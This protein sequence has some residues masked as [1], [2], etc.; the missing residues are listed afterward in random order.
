MT[1]QQVYDAIHDNVSKLPPG[2]WGA[3]YTTGTPDIRWTDADWAKFPRAVR[4]CQDSGSDDTADVL[5]IENG[6]ATDEDAAAWYPRARDAFLA[7][8][9]PGQRHPALY[10]SA[11]FVTGLVNTL[12]AHGIT[13]GPSLFPANW[14]EADAAVRAEIAKAG[15]PFPVIGV[16]NHNFNSDDESLIAESWLTA[17][18]SRPFFT[19]TTNGTDTIG[20]I[21]ASRGYQDPLN[22]VAEQERISRVSA[23][24][25]VGSAVP[26]K[27][28]SWHSIHP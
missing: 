25:L 3:G 16:Q 7:G 11:A 15:G 19:H 14:G 20:Q 5:D 23:R 8:K 10:R 9:R 27:G 17:V 21:S 2:N 1:I 24:G 13:S 6:A 22:W 28:E 18:S 26:A 12:I 4:I